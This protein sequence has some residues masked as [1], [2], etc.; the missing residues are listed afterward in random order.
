MRIPLTLFYRIFLVSLTLFGFQSLQAQ[1]ISGT[2]TGDGDG[3]PGVNVLQQGTS[4]GT[5]TDVNGN[6]T[7][8]LEGENPVLLFTS[9][10]YESETITVGARTIID[11]TMMADLT[12][13]TEVVVTALGITKEKRTL[14]YSTQEVSSQGIEE[15]RPVNITEA[16]SG[17]VAGIAITT[18]GAGVGAPTKVVLRGNRSLQSNGSQPL[19]VIDGVPVGGSI[20]D[21][22]PNDIANIS[23][24]KGGNAAALYGSRANNGAIIVTTKSGEGLP[25]GVTSTLGFNYQVNSPILLTKYQNEFGQGSAGIYSPAAFT[26]WGPRMTGQVVDHWSND[27]NYLASVGGTYP[28]TAQP[29]NV[30][31]FFQNGHTIA[32]SA[33][34][35]IKNENSNTNIN[36]TNTDGKGIV[37]ENNLNRHY[38]NIRNTTTLFDKLTVDTKVNYIRSNFSDVLTSGESFD[39]PARYAY[40]LP[41]N[42]R[43]QDLEYYQF[44]NDEGQLRQHFYVPRSNEAGNPYWTANNVQRPRVNERVLGMLSLKYQITEDLSI[45]ARSGI[46]RR[47]NFEEF[48][49][50]TDTYIVADQGSYSKTFNTDIEWNSDLLLSYQKDL[51]EN[52]SI[53]LNAGANLRIAKFE[54]I[55]GFGENFNVENLFSLGNTL[56]PRPNEAFAEREQQSVY[57]FGEIGFYNAIFLSGSFRNDWSSTL[58]E[59][60]RSYSYPSVGLT[61]VVSDLVDLPSAISFF[62]VRGSWAEVG[63][64]TAPYRLSREATV[65]AGTIS[66]SPTLPLADLR[67]ERT[68]TWE[69]GFDLRFLEDNLRFDF[70]YYKSNTFDQLFATNVPVASGVSRV[71]LNGADIQNQGIEIVLG[72]TPVSTS[73]FSWDLTANFAR[74]LSEVVAITDDV[75]VLIQGS[76]FLNEYQIR[77]GEPFGIQYSRGFERDD[78]GNVLID[79][80]G[81]PVIT[82]GKTVPVSNFQ[83][84]WLMGINNTFKY[85]NFTLRALVDMRQGG[86]VTVFTEAIMAGSGLLD[87]TA[88]GRDGSLVFGENVF[89][90]ETAVLVDETGAPTGTP[91]NISINAEDLWN[92]LGGRNTPVGEAFIRDASNIRLRELSFGYSI[93]ESVL[94][95]LPFRSAS[96]SLVGR[97]LFFLTNKTEYF[98]P[99]AVQSVNNNAEGLNSFALPTTRSFGVSVNLGF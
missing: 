72:V 2:V 23:V 58:P 38:L 68:T 66:L 18:T 83:P 21:I 39:N 91:N 64:D 40:I 43:T 33:G 25:E 24:L 85:K 71:F 99:E 95:N 35:N 50:Y 86:Q 56:Q 20:A 67:P 77:E 63:N 96:V 97:N 22:S 54:S 81:L 5:V 19:Y 61:A 16:L 4:I 98:D 49:R 87:Y 46:D 92:R 73:T 31:D 60:N 51:S 32:V 70:T 34:V 42:L 93:P 29:D 78:N 76:G 69:A 79:A 55:G 30:R 45:L 47:T 65:D 80:T 84:D 28:F 36:Y 14:T 26:S 3:L 89:A 17:K 90:G 15:A 57:A 74:N 12:E 37:P 52:I 7:I 11:I 53:G 27:P 48:I 88:Q 59:A 62:K 75:D 6:Y 1:T 13:L 9:V 8:S 44:T 82:A 41:R 94:A 10:G